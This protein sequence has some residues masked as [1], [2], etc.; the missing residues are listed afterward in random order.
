MDFIFLDHQREVEWLLF[1]LA[2][3]AYLLVMFLVQAKYLRILKWVLR[4]ERVLLSSEQRARLANTSRSK[5]L[6]LQLL[7]YLGML[8]V[9]LLHIG[10]YLL[11]ASDD[12]RPG[13]FVTIASECGLFALL[14]SVNFWLKG[15]STL[16]TQEGPV[17]GV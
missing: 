6:R 11:S 16:P 1:I 17:T 13:Y 2:A 5:T 8:V 14:M 10:V 9:P 4:S 3:P 12:L 15:A 7:G